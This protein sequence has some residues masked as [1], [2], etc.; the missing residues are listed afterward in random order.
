MISPK[1]P[2]P[3][4]DNPEQFYPYPHS[5][6]PYFL[7]ETTELSDIPLASDISAVGLTESKELLTVGHNNDVLIDYLQNSARIKLV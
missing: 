4:K 5:Y 6:V 1:S 7:A 3:H 2:V